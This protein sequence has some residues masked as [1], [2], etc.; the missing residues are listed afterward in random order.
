L[1]RTRLRT[2]LSNLRQRTSAPTAR[3]HWE[4]VEPRLLFAGTGLAGTYF[5]DMD[6]T[7]AVA[8][9]LDAK[10][11]FDWASNAPIAGVAP[12]TYGVRWAGQVEPQ[13]SETYT[14]HTTGNDGVRLWVNGRQLVDDWNDH[15]A[16]EKAGSISLEAGRLYDIRMDYFQHYGTAV[17]KLEWESD[18]QAREVVPTD[19]LYPAALE[20]PPEVQPPLVPNPSDP[21]PPPPVGGDWNLVFRDEFAGPQLDPVWRTVQHWDDD[22][23][24][25]GSGE[26]QAYDATG[27]SVDGGL[28]SL[29]ARR[30]TKYGMPY[31]SGMVQAGGDD[32]VPDGPRFSFRYGY[33]EFRAKL[34]TGQGIWPAIWMLPASY[35]DDNGELDVLEVIGSEPDNANFSLHRNGLDNT[36][37][38]TGPDFSRKFHTI[39]VDWQA[40]HVSW[41]VDGIERARM[42]DPALICPEAM[43][44]ML[45]VAVGGD[46]PGAPD[47]TT[48]FPASMD[49]DYVRVWQAAAPARVVGRQVFYNHSAADGA[50][51]RATNDDDL[52]VATEKAALLPG[53]TATFGNVTSY[54]RGIN[55]VMVDVLG[56]PTSTNSVTA[57]AFDFKAG[58]GGDPASWQDAPAPSSVTVRRGAGLGGSDRVTLTW[59][60]GAIKDTW[61]RV[62]VA[63][64]GP[65]NLPKADVFYFGN[66]AGETGEGTSAPVVTAADLGRTLS[67]QFSDAATLRYDFNRDGEVDALDAAVVRSNLHRALPLITAPAEG[68]ES[69]TIAALPVVVEPLRRPTSRRHLWDE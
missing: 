10:V 21:V 19:R 63:A 6:L 48:A 23:S 41:Y 32:D 17:A 35:H 34:P 28:L 69:P 25:G 16:T 62:T 67:H 5:D 57:D 61:L 66:L 43:Y 40:D 56:L 54:S 49:V 11:D 68:V 65:V 13:F 46:W 64:G 12:D 22:H 38:W 55:G 2:L 27:V 30:E 36:D 53:Q 58:I 18:S 4:S 45:N 9:R 26:L 52:A 44:P 31:V 1:A 24:F 42:T 47:A 37:D 8:V 60:D 14:F 7:D 15:P 50:D 29:T 39:G 59:A 51:A 33:L 20:L 3:A